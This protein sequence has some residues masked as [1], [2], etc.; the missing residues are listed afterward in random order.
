MQRF[1]NLKDCKF[2]GGHNPPSNVP[3]IFSKAWSQSVPP[4]RKHLNCF[5]M[6]KVDQNNFEVFLRVFFALICARKTRR[7]FRG[8]PPLSRLQR[9]FSLQ[10]LDLVRCHT[11][12]RLVA[13]AMLCRDGV[14]RFTPSQ[15]WYF[16]HYVNWKIWATDPTK[17]PQWNVRK[18]LASTKIENNG[19]T[20]RKFK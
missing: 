6:T 12:T 20:H 18:I 10:S 8:S 13:L 4:S 1:Q 3:I 17:S 11:F 15:F 14:D 2:S 19:V 7:Q 16:G 9:T 5:W